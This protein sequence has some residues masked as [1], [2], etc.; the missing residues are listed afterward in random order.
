M[1]ITVRLNDIVDGLE[2]QSDEYRTCLDLDTGQVESVDRQL[3]RMAEDLAD[4]EEP[5]LPGWQK[6]QW[7]IAK[8]MISTDRFVAL[9]SKHDIHEWQI[10]EDFS[11]SVRS[12][13]IREE[14]LIAIHGTGAF[15]MFK[16]TSRRLGV[17]DAWYEFRAEA[18][19]EIARDWCKDHKIAWVEER[20]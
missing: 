18:I 19:K 15:R 5:E 3:L 2:L 10:M 4:D 7:E 14:L 9:P 16:Q 12:E 20:D 6:P 17:E 11:R 8:R 13:K 1:S